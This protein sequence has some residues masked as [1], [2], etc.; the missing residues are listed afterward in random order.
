MMA[1]PGEI[2]VGLDVGTTKVTAVV[3]EVKEGGQLDIIG[4]GVATSNGI[5]KGVLVNVNDTCE[6][7]QKAIHEAELMAGC[8]VNAVYVGISGGHI[9][10]FNNRGVVAIGGSEVTEQD[11]RRVIENARAVQIPA[12]RQMIATVPQEFLVD[13]ND[14]IKQPVGIAGS[15]LQVNVHIITA[16]KADVLNVIQCCERAKLHVLNVFSNMR[17]SAR[18][19]LD[20]DEKEL[21]VVMC[22]VGGGTTDIAVYHN[23]AIVHSAVLAQ[24]GDQVSSDIAIGLRTGT[25]HADAIKL[26]YGCAMAAMV[27]ESEDIEVPSIGNREP[28]ARRRTL[29]CDI[30]EPRMEEI[31][32]SIAKEVKASNFADVLG[33]GV[34]VTGGTALMPGISEL[35]EE[36]LE[37]PVRIGKPKE[38]GGLYEMVRSP[39]F[40]SAVG[41]V[42]Q[43]AHEQDVS[44]PAQAGATLRSSSS[45]SSWFEKFADWVRQSF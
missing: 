11:V 34:V 19:V 20:R 16:R 30:I 6:A 41:L 2:I 43:G 13:D 44:G 23:G 4:V 9:M 33:A 15:M 1:K 21:G 35:G 22:D 25:A 5:S 37:M 40:A 7:I 45:G 32:Q 28:V 42:L 38:V 24:G 3:G 27:D 39:T 29:L 26:R 10:S 14:G 36:V 18:A 31:Y 17:A 12:D 8:T